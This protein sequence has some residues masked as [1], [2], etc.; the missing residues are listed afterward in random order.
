MKLRAVDRVVKG[1]ETSDGG[2][3]RLKRSIGTPEL[4]HVDPFLLLD[5]F[6]SDA[7]DRLPGRFPR[8]PPPRLRDSHLHAGWSHA[9][10]RTTR[11]TG[12]ISRQAACS[13]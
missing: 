9:S 3:V 2:G 5:E 12:A 13:G 6:K 8:P 11:A 1:Q 7:A 10:T 4:D